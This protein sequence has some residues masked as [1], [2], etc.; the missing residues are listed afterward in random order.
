MNRQQQDFQERLARLG[1]A[2]Q[3]PE[4]Q[5]IPPE[6]EPLP[7]KYTPRNVAPLDGWRQN[8][9]Y[10]LKLAGA[11]LFGMLAVFAARY[12]RFHMNGGALTGEDADLMMVL[13]AGMAAAVGFAM[14]Q[15]FRLD[16]KEFQAAQTFGVAAM[17]ATMHNAVHWAPKPFEA[18]FSPQ[19][20]S[21]VR[22]FTE[23]NS[24]LF[25]G[26][27]FMLTPDTDARSGAPK[28]N[29]PGF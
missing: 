24:I 21:D 29:R 27:S 16:G 23:P 6:H 22:E 5:V 18:I 15:A 14:T 28:I 25:R 8:A 4:P 9:R 13:D 20:V 11:F 7:D 3:T 1:H 19:W 26:V 2:S 12:V 10:P 17:V